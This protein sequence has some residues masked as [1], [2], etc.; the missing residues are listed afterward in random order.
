MDPS[1]RGCVTEVPTHPALLCVKEASNHVSRLWSRW[2]AAISLFLYD[3]RVSL[4]CAMEVSLFACMMM[5]T[6]PL[7]F[8]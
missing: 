5:S 7:C 6:R 2:Y 1:L 8:V 4:A 3:G